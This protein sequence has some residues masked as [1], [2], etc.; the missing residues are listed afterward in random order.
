MVTTELMKNDWKQEVI[1]L[2]TLFMDRTPDSFIEIKIFY[3]LA[4]SN[5]DSEIGFKRAME[6]KIFY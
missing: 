3:C 5:S 2:F 6:L 4:L 1:S